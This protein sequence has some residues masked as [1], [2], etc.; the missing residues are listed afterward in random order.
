MIFSTDINIYIGYWFFPDGYIF[1][2]TNE[3]DHHGEIFNNE[4]FN[5]YKY[6][7][8]PKTLKISSIPNIKIKIF[9]YGFIRMS[10][11]NNQ[12]ALDF[13]NK[14]DKINLT[15]I[16]DL[17]YNYIKNINKIFY[18]YDIIISQLSTHNIEIFNNI[19]DFEEKLIKIYA[20]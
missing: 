10:A 3:N 7:N 14:I 12:I 20:S 19:T 1:T 16:L 8:I 5:L 6:L 9:E 15:N 2:C 13:Y 11:Y 4:K 17:V 18:T